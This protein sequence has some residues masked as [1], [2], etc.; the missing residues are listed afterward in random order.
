M[1]KK[2]PPADVVKNI[3]MKLSKL[4]MWR[5]ILSREPDENDIP[6]LFVDSAGWSEAVKFKYQSLKTLA[7]TNP[8]KALET[9]VS[10]NKRSWP[11]SRRTPTCCPMK[12]LGGLRMCAV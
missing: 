11:A 12:M 1:K 4:K 5:D 9:Q 10:W 3:N 2:S 7:Q 8:T 6:D